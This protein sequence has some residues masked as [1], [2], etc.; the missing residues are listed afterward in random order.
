MKFLFTIFLGWAVSCGPDKDTYTGAVGP[1][2]MP[3]RKLHAGFLVVDGVYNTELMAPLDVFQHTLFHT[4]YGMDVSLIGPT[5]DPITTFEGL[6][7]IPNYSLADTIPTIDVL[8][9]PSARHSM[10]EDLKNEQMIS[11]VKKQSQSALYVM[12][13]CDG[14]FVLAQAGVLN[15]VDCTTFPADINQFRKQFPTLKVYEN[16]SF[17]HDRKVIT[18]V[19][20][21]K[22]YD[23][24]LY[25]VELLYGRSVAVKI[26]QG[27][28][29][30]WD[31]TQVKNHRTAR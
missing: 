8:I 5:H 18:S 16:V 12:S 22:S 14:A 21:A 27:L 1:P 11:F 20:G 10:G 19:G 9:V 31:L 7:I 28:V 23:A 25:L 4:E 26:G 13:L 29:I 15:G 3:T 2:V 17:V 30:D 24:A 6:R